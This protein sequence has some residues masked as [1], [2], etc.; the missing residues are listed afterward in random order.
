MFKP[1]FFR[2]IKSGKLNQA[3][4]ADVT[5]WLARAGESAQPRDSLDGMWEPTD[6]QKDVST[7][8]YR[9]QRSNAVLAT[10]FLPM[11]RLLKRRGHGKSTGYR[12]PRRTAKYGTLTS[13][14]LLPSQTYR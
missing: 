6:N 7:N 10:E 5:R 2:W 1:D 3:T 12:A 13:R 11:I 9:G 4:L 14:F 8:M